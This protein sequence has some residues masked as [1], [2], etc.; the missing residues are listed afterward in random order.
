MFPT[1]VII[2]YN[3]LKDNFNAFKRRFPTTRLA[4]IVKSN[5]YGHGLVQTSRAFID[6]GAD[7][8]A[9]FRVDEAVRL[10]EARI[11]C[12]VLC[13]LGPLP[14]EADKA[15]ALDN[16]TMGIFSLEQARALSNAAVARNRTIQIHLAV[17]TGM[18]RLGFL[19]DEAPEA[20][21]TVA[22]LPNLELKG[23]YSHVAKADVPDD[24]MTLK[25][26][27]NFR[28]VIPQLPAGC[29]ENHLCASHAL[30]NRIAP[31]LPM[32]RPGICLYKEVTLPG[33]T[34]PLTRDAMTLRTRLVSVKRLPAGHPVSYGCTR[35]LTRDSV[36]GIAPLGYDD[37]VLR[38]LSNRASALVRG[39]RVPFLGRVCMSMIMLDLTD[40]PDAAP[41]D[42]AVLL[43]RQGD[44]A[45]TL[46]E[47]S[48]A[49]QTTWHE[50]LCNI[51]RS[52]AEP[53]HFPS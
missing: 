28:R 20:A 9:V 36:V 51:G 7:L 43:G 1:E 4:A 31:E 42:E 25:Q 3:V 23:I 41:D 12:R 21:R 27:A 17:D 44:D 32:A 45:I 49:A 2:D 5:A 8:L 29:T 50:L 52:N 30:M 39:R 35:I 40:V 26:V 15:A 33:D 10:R 46:E 22:S 6:G 14:H 18:G 37:G 38:S 19:P 48:N 47:L 11:T 24:P 53:H 16:V 13:L 34:A